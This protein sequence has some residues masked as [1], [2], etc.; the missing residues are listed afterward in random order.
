VRRECEDKYGHVVHLGIG[1]ESNEGEVYVKFDRIQGG[2]NAIR[3][4]NG[5]W[6]GGR[7]LAAQYV[8]EAV[9]NINFPKAANV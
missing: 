7:V 5:R 9:Y 1:M 6:F 2:T 4:L 8:V 3:G